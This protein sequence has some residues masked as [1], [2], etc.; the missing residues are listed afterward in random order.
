MKSGLYFLYGFKKKT[1]LK[2]LYLPFHNT[3]GHQTWQ[4]SNLR[5]GDPAFQ[6]TFLTFDYVVM[7]QIQ[8]PFICTFTIPMAIKLG[9]VVIYCFVRPYMPRSVTFW[10]CGQ[11]TNSKNLYLHF[12]NTYGYQTWKRSNLRLGT[13][14]SKSR[15]LLITWSHGKFEKLISAFAQY[16]W[17]PNFAEWQ[18]TL[19]ASHP[20]IHLIFWCCSHV[21]NENLITWFPQCLGPP[22]LVEY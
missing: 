8:K 1:K 11:V 16:L 10:S 22:N 12:R 9:K 3:Y 18:L 20:L 6:V 19:G 7:W 21:K 2:A 17:P 5:W 15:D 14:P 4:S 13:P